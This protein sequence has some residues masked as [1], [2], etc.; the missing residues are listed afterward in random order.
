[1]EKKGDTIL[2]GLVQCNEDG[3]QAT[4]QVLNNISGYLHYHDHGLYASRKLRDYL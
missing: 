1:M 2:L 4:V 3:I